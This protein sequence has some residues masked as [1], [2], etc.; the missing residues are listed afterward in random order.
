M[1]RSRMVWRRPTWLSTYTA[2]AFVLAAA[3][4]AGAVLLAQEAT[5]PSGLGRPPTAAELRDGLVGPDGTDLPDGRGTAV[6]GAMVFAARGCTKC[7]GPT[8]TEGPSVALVGGQVTSFSNYWPISH[9]PF[10]PSIWDFIRRVMP[11]DRP[12]ILT[13]DETYALTAFLLYRNGIIGED[14]VMDAG[15]LPTVKM[16]HRDDYQLPAPWTPDTRRGFEILPAR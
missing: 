2:S 13:V 14:D 1:E 9:W 3:M 11:Y 6:E 4:L 7:H 16:P 5:S 10:A 15:S 12:G 8:G